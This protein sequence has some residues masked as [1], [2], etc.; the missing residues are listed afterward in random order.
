[1]CKKSERVRYSSAVINL[2]D[3]VH[4][5]LYIRSDGQH[6]F[7]KT[8]LLVNCSLWKIGNYSYT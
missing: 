7:I 1:M 6:T 8:P 3:L 5:T 2:Q 4:L